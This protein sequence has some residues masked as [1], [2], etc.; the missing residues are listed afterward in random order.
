MKHVRV[1]EVIPAGM[2]FVEASDGGRF[3]PV[4][5]A[6][7]WDLGALPPG[8]ETAVSSK[9]IARSPGTQQAKITATGPA[10][11]TAAV[12]SDVDVVGRPEL[13][14]ETVSRTGVVVVGDRLTSKIQLKNHGSA[15]AK[16]VSLSIRLPQELKLVEV[17]GGKYTLRDSVIAFDSVPAIGPKETAGFELVMEATSEADVQMNLEISAD[18]LSKPARRSE[19][20]QIAAEIR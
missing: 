16:N 19:T 11:S 13:Q 8:S 4:Q 6:I 18:H 3:D 10:G 20:V 9:L 14:I 15:S 5:R 7:F 17:R 2:E 1:A 12:K